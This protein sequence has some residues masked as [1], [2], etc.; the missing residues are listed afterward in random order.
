MKPDIPMNADEPLQKV[1]SAWR[2]TAPVPPRFAEAVWRRIES[3]ETEAAVTP[4]TVLVNWMVRAMSRP[5]LA[6]AYVAVLLLMGVAGGYWHVREAT[7]SLDKTL[8]SRYVQAVDP[9]Q[10]ARP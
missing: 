10:Q 7:S 2:V 3:A 4:W 9:Y 8:A 5:S 6:K 1:L